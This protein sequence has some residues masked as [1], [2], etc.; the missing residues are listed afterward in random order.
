MRPAGPVLDTTGLDQMLHRSRSNA[1][2]VYEVLNPELELR[3][4]LRWQGDEGNNLGCRIISNLSTP[5][6][7]AA[8]GFF[9][10]Q[11]NAHI[12]LNTHIYHQLPPT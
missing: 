6:I 3:A 2:W 5:N 9:L 7:L 10:L 11:R 4:N 12:M 1:A 8:N